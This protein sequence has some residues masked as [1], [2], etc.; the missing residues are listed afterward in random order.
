V[1]ISARALTARLVRPQNAAGRDGAHAA[2]SDSDHSDHSLEHFIV[3]EDEDEEGVSRATSSIGLRP[4]LC[5]GDATHFRLAPHSTLTSGA[6][7]AEFGSEG[8]QRSM[9]AADLVRCRCGARTDA[10]DPGTLWVQ[11]SNYQCETWVHAACYGVDDET[12]VRVRAVGKLFVV[13]AG[14]LP[15][16]G[17]GIIN[18]NRQM[19]LRL[20][21][22]SA[23]P[24]AV[25]TG[26]TTASHQPWYTP[27][28]RRQQR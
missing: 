3:E 22:A 5:R 15:V 21:P 17:F 8:L 24:V 4:H 16:P 27:P 11:C 20:V 25:K 2:E 19:F 10:A 7:Q 6:R 14:A 12:E 9:E 23:P 18:S 26:S 13:P 28:R 1:L